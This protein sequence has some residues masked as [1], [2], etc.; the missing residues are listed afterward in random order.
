MHFDSF[1]RMKFTLSCLFM[2]SIGVIRYQTYNY[3]GLPNCY[4]NVSLS[5]MNI[6]LDRESL[7]K[8][9]RFRTCILSI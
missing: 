8:D 9:Y 7:Y 4:T 3:D 2:L 1:P 6:K 5:F